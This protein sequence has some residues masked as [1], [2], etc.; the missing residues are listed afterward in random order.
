MIN[1]KVDLLPNNE[2]KVTPIYEGDSNVPNS[3]KQS[4]NEPAK[5]DQNSRKVIGWKR[6]PGEIG[7]EAK[8]IPVYE[9]NKP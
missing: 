9:S 5:T 8:W 2:V 7:E 1:C 4:I 6:A 3:E